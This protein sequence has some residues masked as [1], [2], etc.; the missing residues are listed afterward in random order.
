MQK[1]IGALLLTISLT[2]CSTTY[3][4]DNT[5]NTGSYKPASSLLGVALN[6]GK[7]TAYS[8]PKEARVKHEN[9]V[10]MILDNGSLGETCSWSTDTSNGI[11]KLLVIKPGSMCH[12]LVSNVY[13]N[14][15]ET[16]FQDVACPTANNKW[17]FYDK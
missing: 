12:H 15:R 14:G 3:Y 11:V 17:K 1:V 2:G 9:C 16:A 8:V 7:S 5:I 6:L 4:A 13:Y 10:Y